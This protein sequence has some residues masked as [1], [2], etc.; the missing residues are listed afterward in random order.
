MAFSWCDAFVDANRVPQHSTPPW[1]SFTHVP[2]VRPLGGT[3]RVA[4]QQLCLEARA[5]VLGVKNRTAP[6]TGGELGP[7]GAARPL[8]SGG[9]ATRRVVAVAPSQAC[10]G[11]TGFVVVATQS[12]AASRRPSP[13]HGRPQ[14]PTASWGAF[15]AFCI[16]AVFRNIT[17]AAVAE[18]VPVC[19]CSASCTQTARAPIHAAEHESPKGLRAVSFVS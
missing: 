2:P 18:L 1:R 4:S 3:W 14:I 9:A 11:S 5:S 16:C 6:T 13:G 12:T 15:A 19:V 8:W 17:P 10:R 7:R